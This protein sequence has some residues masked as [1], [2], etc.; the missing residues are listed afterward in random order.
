MRDRDECMVCFKPLADVAIGAEFLV[1]A[2]HLHRVLD[3]GAADMAQ[4][5]AQGRPC[6]C[7]Q[8]G[9]TQVAPFRV[10]MVGKAPTVPVAVSVAVPVVPVAMP[11]AMPVPVV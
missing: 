10:R 1:T 11:L 5:E 2:C 8:C 6:V 3:C 4:R 7:G 9:T